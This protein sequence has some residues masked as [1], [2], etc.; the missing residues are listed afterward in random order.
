MAVRAGYIIEILGNGPM[1]LESMV[2]KM[3]L[4]LE[5]HRTN[6]TL[7]LLPGTIETALISANTPKNLNMP[8][9]VQNCLT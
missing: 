9:L 3:H 7:G 2:L 6:V 8:L 4:M 1:D 5:L